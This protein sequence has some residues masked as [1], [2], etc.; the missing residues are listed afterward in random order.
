VESILERAQKACNHAIV[1]S[2]ITKD[3]VYYTRLDEAILNVYEAIRTNM[4]VKI[5]ETTK[6]L[7]LLIEPKRHYGT[8][9][10]RTKST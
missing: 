6:E 4:V 8:F 7:E 5:L 10:K 1:E 9:I 3:L 2:C